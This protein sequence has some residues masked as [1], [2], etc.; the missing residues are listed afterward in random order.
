MEDYLSEKEQWEAI[1]VWLKE[2]LLWIVAGVAVGAAGLSGYRWYQGHVDQKAIAASSKYEQLADAL[3]HGDRTRALLLLSDLERDYSSSPYVDQARLLVARAYVDSRD[4]D[5]AADE[6]QTVADH[7]KDSE[8]ALVARLRLARV[9]IAQKKPDM[10]LTTLNGMQPGAFAWRYHEVRG[11]AYYA[12]GDKT[13]ALK[14]YL[15]AK[16]SDV[17]GGQ[18]GSELDLKISD[19]AGETTHLAGSAPATPATAATSK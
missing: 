17:G 15:S 8:I 5:K 11:D 9:Q 13:S 1:K 14:E 18:D 19:L 7:A 3:G 6:L 12:K 2:N 10:A 4:L 16:A